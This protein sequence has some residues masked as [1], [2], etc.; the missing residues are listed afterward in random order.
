MREKTESQESIQISCNFR[1]A[2]NIIILL[3]CCIV[4]FILA[5]VKATCL[6]FATNEVVP[7]REQMVLLFVAI[8][9]W[10]GVLIMFMLLL[11]QH[12]RKEILR[13][14]SNGL[15]HQQVFFIPFTHFRFTWKETFLKKGDF[16][17]AKFYSVRIDS[18]AEEYGIEFQTKQLPLRCFVS[19]DNNFRN[20]IRYNNLS[21]VEI[22]RFV[23]V[24]NAK[25]RQLGVA[26]KGK[27]LA[28]NGQNKP[29]APDEK[30]RCGRWMIDENIDGLTF[31][32]NVRIPVRII[33]THFLGGV[34]LVG[35]VFASPPPD[36]TRNMI[37]LLMIV[38]SPF[39]IIGFLALWAVLFMLFLYFV[40][41]SIRIERDGVRYSRGVFGIG[42]DKFWKYDEFSKVEVSLSKKK[43]SVFS[44]L[45]DPELA[46][47]PDG[48]TNP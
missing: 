47:S 2:R 1:S 21:K 26:Q 40:H 27:F 18:H 30:Q 22:H 7:L 12:C 5:G 37:I 19:H 35:F 48:R 41:Y 36:A 11:W 14:D 16:G 46:L 25:A 8:F 38:F 43:L 34:F 28:T 13:M 17:F 15:F 24:L 23:E 4:G 9:F 44:Y 39:L 32:R 20:A 3:C 31:R 42:R 29:I 45:F 6:L 10:L 33:L